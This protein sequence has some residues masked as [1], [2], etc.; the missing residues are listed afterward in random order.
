MTPSITIFWDHGVRV[1]RT[2]CWCIWRIIS[3]I[4]LARHICFF[5]ASSRFNESI[6]LL[7]DKPISCQN[8]IYLSLNLLFPGE[9]NLPLNFIMN[10]PHRVAGSIGRTI[11]GLSTTVVKRIEMCRFG[12]GRIVFLLGPWSSI[13]LPLA[14]E[15]SS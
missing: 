3:C 8:L 2:L 5:C 9:V 7:A 6:Y 10:V 4:G 1:Q 11:F 12:K 14:S 15:R 13:V